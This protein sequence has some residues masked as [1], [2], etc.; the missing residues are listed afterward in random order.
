MQYHVMP[1]A[2]DVIMAINH[3]AYNQRSNK[4]N[5]PKNFGQFEK[6][7]EKKDKDGIFSGVRLG[8]KH[9]ITQLKDDITNMNR[10]LPQFDQF[11]VNNNKIS[12]SNQQNN[13]K[14]DQKIN[15]KN[16]NQKK[17]KKNV[18]PHV[19]VTGS[20]YLAGNVLKDLKQKV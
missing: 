2:H 4:E 10:N 19:Y 11:I 6:N 18:K 17:S 7:K 5:T 13:T 15:P 14:N 1:S 12:K 9:D 16:Q 8:S 3:L 20:L